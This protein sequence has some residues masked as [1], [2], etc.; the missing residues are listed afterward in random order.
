MRLNNRIKIKLAINE[1]ISIIK[2]MASLLQKLRVLSLNTIKGT[3][4]IAISNM[5]HADKFLH[6]NMPANWLFMNSLD[7]STNVLLSRI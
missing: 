2:K 6:F 4:I 1:I 7:F 3:A 5:M